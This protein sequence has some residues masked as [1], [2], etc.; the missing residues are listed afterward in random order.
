M[1]LFYRESGN[2]DGSFLLFIHGGGVSGWMWDKQVQYFNNYHCIVPDLLKQEGD[3][4]IEEFSIKNSA[5]QLLMLIEKKAKNKKV[6]VIGFSLGAQIAMQMV[7]MKPKLID[8]VMINSALVRPFPFAK[9]FISSSVKLTFPFIKNKTFSKLQAKTLYIGDEYFEKYYEESSNM[10]QD[11]L[12]NI[13][14]DNMAFE[15]P[16][17]FSKVQAKIL[18][19]VGEKEKGIMKKSAV[20]IVKHNPNCEGVILPNIGHGIPLAE[21]DRF[22]HIVEEWM[23]DGKVPNGK[24]INDRI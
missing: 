9:Y 4:D 24:L 7:S 20:D 19:T 10:N 8:F 12:I 1:T 15:I 22:N 17:N 18:V 14:K 5:E 13:L 3:N 2:I 6:I 16:E 11:I 21:P 23:K